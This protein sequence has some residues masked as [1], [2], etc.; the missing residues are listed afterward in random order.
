MLSLMLF[1]PIAGALLVALAPAGGGANPRRLA[2]VITLATF[3]LSLLLLQGFHPHDGYQYR[4]Q[5]DWLTPNIGSFK[6][7]YHVGVDGI[8]IVLVVLTTFLSLLS[9]LISWTI[10]HRQKEYFAWILALETGVL[11][12]FV[13]LD[14]I[15]FFLFWEVEL[16]PMYL[17][18]SIWG[19]GRKEYSALKFL[20]Y[21]IAGSS[22]MLVGILALGF[23]AKTFD[24]IQL[25]QMGPLVSPLIPATAMFYLIGAAFI[26][27]LPVA[28]FHTWLPDAHSDAP[29]AVSVL[30]AGVLL[31]MGGYGMIRLCVTIFPEVAKQQAGVM[32]FFAAVSVIYGACITLRQTDIKRL[33]AY[34]SVSHMGYVLLGLSAMGGGFQ[35][36]GIGLTGATL[37]MFTHG[38]ITGLLF[39]MVGL[40]YE[41]THTREISRM[42]GLAKHWPF[43]G[44]GMSVAGFASL[45]LPALSGFVAELMVFLGTFRKY[46]LWTSIAVVG[47]VL[48]AGYILWTIQRVMH[49]PPMEEWEHHYP[50]ATKWYER[51]PAVALG[52][53]IVAVGVYP[54]PLLNIIEPSVST[55]VQRLGSGA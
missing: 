13:S 43:I 36:R 6:L 31:K 41:R 8:S 37:Q 7:Q 18:I 10:S 39:T 3:V 4:Q 53:V 27:K 23:S 52:L 33:I 28:P 21:T 30:L 19:S 12:V 2:L 47:V 9:V 15:Q 46:E 16:L 32:A 20:L 44:V 34:S 40:V 5:F 26:V 1:L 45:G 48:S 55:L 35:A 42:R 25:G 11:G 29:T 51:I 24:I 49:G 22:L 54:Q 50:D 17:L 38:T 14:F